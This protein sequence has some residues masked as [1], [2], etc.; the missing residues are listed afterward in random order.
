MPKVKRWAQYH[1]WMR[2]W[3]GG[4]E[5]E[6]GCEVGGLEL[7]GAEREHPANRDQRGGWL[8]C[9]QTPSPPPS[10]TSGAASGG[11]K[12]SSKLNTPDHSCI[13]SCPEY[14]YLKPKTSTH[15]VQSLWNWI[16]G[17]SDICVV[18]AQMHFTSKTHKSAAKIWDGKAVFVSRDSW[19]REMMGEGRWGGEREEAACIRRGRLWLVD[20]GGG[21][22]ERG[23]RKHLFTL[24]AFCT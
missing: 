6:E 21:E 20:G 2:K 11:L 15:A 13:H 5:M 18:R 17:I 8:T 4:W 9:S 22:N 10:S 12:S 16:W 24:R 1:S 3:W 23:N 7:Q 19:L 14:S